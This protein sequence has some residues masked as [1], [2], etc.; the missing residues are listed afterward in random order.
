MNNTIE[1][2]LEISNGERKT[3]FVRQ[4]LAEQPNFEPYTGKFIK[5]RNMNYFESI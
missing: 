4:V 3:E 5:K 2:I 1:L